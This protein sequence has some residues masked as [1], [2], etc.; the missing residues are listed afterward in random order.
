MYVSQGLGCPAAGA[1][2]FLSMFLSNHAWNGTVELVYTVVALCYPWLRHECALLVGPCKSMGPI[3]AKVEVNLNWSQFR[4][5]FKCEIHK[6]KEFE[7]YM[8]SLS[9]CWQIIEH[10]CPVFQLL[11][12]NLLIELEFL[13][14]LTWPHP[15]PYT[16]SLFLAFFSIRLLLK[17]YF[18]CFVMSICFDFI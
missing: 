6:W 15:I 3:P 16:F 17:I 13:N 9:V 14:W 18:C 1:A 4:K 8:A 11:N 7:R 10:R 2:V 12:W 5:W